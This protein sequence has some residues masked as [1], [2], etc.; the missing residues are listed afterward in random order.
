MSLKS[1]EVNVRKIGMFD[2]WK[3]TPCDSVFYL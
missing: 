2:G 3:M 1:K